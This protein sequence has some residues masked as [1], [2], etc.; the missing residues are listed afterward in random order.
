MLFERHFVAP[1]ARSSD[2]VWGKAMSR[3]GILLSVTLLFSALAGAQT[4]PRPKSIPPIEP[5]LRDSDPRLVALGAWEVIKREDDSQT[6]L[7]VDL[8]EH[9]DPAQRHRRENTDS[10]DAMTVVLDALIQRQATP[11]PAAV[12]AVAHAFP[13]QALLLASRLQPEDGEP[14]LQRWY[15][16]GHRLDRPHFERDGESRLLLSRVAAMFLARDYPDV[17]AASLLADT[18]AEL[19]VSVTDPA[20]P[21]VDRCFFECDPPLPCRPETV[22]YVQ[23]GW[24]PVFTYA[25]EENDPY[26][27]RRSGILIYAGGDTVTW[28]RVP[29]QV[30]L[31]DCFIPRPLTPVT[32]YRLLA[33]MLHV[34]ITAIPWAPQMNLTLPWTGDEHFLHD[35]S[36]QVHAEE[37]LLRST[38]QAFFDKGLLTRTQLETIRPRLSVELFDDRQTQGKPRAKLP[39]PAVQDERTMCRVASLP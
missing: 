32:R 21:G 26:I 37:A 7:L 38:V 16:E 24:P 3:L 28:R 31:D 6:N 35:L 36:E 30:H 2:R 17:A 22:D 19:L 20:S 14:I 29:R 4:P 9:W 10:Y 12:L 33:D 18:R 8:A 13:D 27:E 15:Q 11:S 25:L 39:I 5:L 23:N 1:A 34:R